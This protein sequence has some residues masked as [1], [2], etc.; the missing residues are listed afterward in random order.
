MR[1]TF[2]RAAVALSLMLISSSGADAANIDLL[3]GRWI[4]KF[5]NGTGMV[6]EFTPTAISSVPMDAS[7]KA[8]EPPTVMEVS[9]RDLGDGIAIEFKGGGG[10]MA[11][12][13]GRQTMLLVFPGMGS[14]QLSRLEP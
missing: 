5:E 9:Y 2:K 3:F 1:E 11:V 7:G 4:E 6:M 12:V 10:L 14:H 8:A 13:K